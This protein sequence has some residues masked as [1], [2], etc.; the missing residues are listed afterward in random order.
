[1]EFQAVDI[2]FEL[3]PDIHSDWEC[4][5]NSSSDA[6]LGPIPFR[7]ATLVQE[8]GPPTKTGDQA[9][10]R[11]PS[12]ESENHRVP[13]PAHNESEELPV[14]KRQCRTR[15]HDHKPMMYKTSVHPADEFL[16]PAQFARMNAQGRKTTAS[17]EVLPSD[18]KSTR[19]NSAASSSH[20]GTTRRNSKEDTI[21][22]D[23]HSSNTADLYQSVSPHSSNFNRRRSS[24]TSSRMEVPNY[25]MKYY[26]HSTRSPSKSLTD[27]H[28]VD[29]IPHMIK[30]FV[31][32]HSKLPSGEKNVIAM[33][34][35]R[36]PIQTLD[37]LQPRAQILMALMLNVPVALADFHSLEFNSLLYFLYQSRYSMKM[38]FPQ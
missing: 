11:S 31:R 3:E 33:L 4:H 2:P 35:Q 13:N 17:I 23:G 9:I 6:E 29:S 21:K 24:R 30:Y 22:N 10:I 37:L 28:C 14:P 19:S 38:K 36:P 34:D 16:R 20:D 15:H 5:S 32:L 18:K 1:M 8:P 12:A 25:D 26:S 27:S 7:R